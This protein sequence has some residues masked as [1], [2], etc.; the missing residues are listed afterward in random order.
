M[1]TTA[2]IFRNLGGSTG[3]EN[4]GGLRSVGLERGLGVFGFAAVCAALSFG[5]VSPAAAQVRDAGRADAM[6]VY[7]QLGR[8][9]HGDN[10]NAATF[11]V[12]GPLFA[13]RDFLGAR[14]HGYWDAYVSQW[15]APVTAGGSNE[16]YVQLGLVPTARWR[17]DQGRS[18]WFVDAG[19]GI[20]YLNDDYVTPNRAFG[21]RWNFTE[22]VAL[23]R[24]F[25]DHEQHELAL[26]LSHFSNAGIR[27][28][29][30]G[31]N[32]L[33]VRYAMRF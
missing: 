27:K 25:G 26:S 2:R 23:G 13:E 6:G 21:S 12:T 19:L 20:T 24:S 28:P 22:R 31:E 1:K 17:L 11:G 9:P 14:V 16:S 4:S 29:N 15:R 33:Q 7:V 8:A 5:M 30:P 10:T 3:L 18:S 32:F